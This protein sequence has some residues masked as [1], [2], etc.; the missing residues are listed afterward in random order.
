MLIG[1][2]DSKLIHEKLVWIPEGRQMLLAIIN[3]DF[4]IELYHFGRN[5]KISRCIGLN[6][7]PDLILKLFTSSKDKNNLK[8]FLGEAQTMDDDSD[9]DRERVAEMERECRLLYLTELHAEWQSKQRCIR[10]VANDYFTGEINN[11]ITVAKLRMA[12]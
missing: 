3:S 4:N 8:K 11:S 9:I 12:Y 5:N 6:Q 10:I 1:I 2:D 7:G